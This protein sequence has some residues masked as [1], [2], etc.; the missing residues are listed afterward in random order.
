MF[1]NKEKK[2]K[3][4]AVK[5]QA[6]DVEDSATVKKWKKRTYRRRK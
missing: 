6:I 5:E 3:E 4:Q 1:E 2:V